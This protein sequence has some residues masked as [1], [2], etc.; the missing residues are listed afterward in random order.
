MSIRT[1]AQRSPKLGRRD[2]GNRRHKPR[3]EVGI[4]YHFGAKLGYIKKA[5]RRHR[6]R[7]LFYEVIKGCASVAALSTNLFLPIQGIIARNFAPTSSIWCASSV[8]AAWLLKLGCPVALEHPVAREA[9]RLDVLQH[10]LHL[11]L[12]FRRDDAR[13]VTYSPYSARI[14][15]RVIH[16]GD[17]APRR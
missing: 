10:A 16:V 1:T 4:N 5:R 9:A 12:R 13:T 14:R 11:S 15:D 7:A 6:L 17:A 2:H 3:R 8:T